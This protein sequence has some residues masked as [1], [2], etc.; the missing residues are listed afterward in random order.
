[1]LSVYMNDDTVKIVEGTIKSKKFYIKK[2]CETETKAAS[3][4]TGNIKDV[5]ELSQLIQGMLQ[6]NEIKPQK[7]IVVL[8][9][10][11]IVFR[12]TIVPALPPKKLKI[13]LTTEFFS[14]NKQKN[15]VIDYVIESK[16][17][18]EEKKNKYKIHITYQTT[19]SIQSIA[20]V[21]NELGIKCN[22]VD[23]G[24]NS[25]S[26][27][28]EDFFKDVP[29]TNLLIDYKDTFLSLYV[30]EGGKRKYSKSSIIYA[31]PPEDGFGELDYFINEMQNNVTSITRY[32]E[33]RNENT[34]ISNIYI[35][36]NVKVFSDECVQMLANSTK[37]KVS[38]LP[39]PDN[40][41]GVDVIDFNS[42]SCAIG[43]LIRR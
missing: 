11:R 30:F 17:K 38:Y 4:E 7:A 3:I 28:L 33:Q 42:Y 37:L 40:V 21:L 32:Y 18:D 12:E 2:V 39:C 5:L 36:G 14:D 41:I 6:D 1:M 35:T 19:D 10:S 29:G 13:V 20:K 16:F 9:N 15:N 34:S 43:G 24:Q 31:K 25:T 8:D 27:L 26:K 23:I 22:A